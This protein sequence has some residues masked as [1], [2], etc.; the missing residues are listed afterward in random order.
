MYGVQGYHAYGL[1]KLLAAVAKQVHMCGRYH[2]LP[3][4]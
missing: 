1:D 4:R 3:C 2:T